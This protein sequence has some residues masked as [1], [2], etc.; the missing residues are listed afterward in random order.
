MLAPW[1]QSPAG[2]GEMDEVK[3]SLLRCKVFLRGRGPEGS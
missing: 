1:L 3:M 2:V